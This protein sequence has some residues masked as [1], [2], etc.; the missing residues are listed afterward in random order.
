MTEERASKIQ[1]RFPH[2]ESGYRLGA[3]NLM[4]RRLSEF[5]LGL[6]HTAMVCVFWG[7]GVVLKEGDSEMGEG[8]RFQTCLT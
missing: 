1:G 2:T 6:Y 5:P 8:Q 3:E 4:S 7:E